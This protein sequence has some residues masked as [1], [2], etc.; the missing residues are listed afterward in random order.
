MEMPAPL[1]PLSEVAAVTVENTIPAARDAA[2]IPP[3]VLVVG[4]TRAWN[5]PAD[6][7]AD[8]AREALEVVLVVV[9][10]HLARQGP[11]AGDDRRGVTRYQDRHLLVA[12]PGLCVFVVD[13]LYDPR[14]RLRDAVMEGLDPFAMLAGDDP[15]LVLGVEEREEILA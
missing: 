8:P 3:V 13:V 11:A 1:L 2:G 14:Q 5:L 9:I 10:R 12:T 7:L 4:F 15:R 6:E